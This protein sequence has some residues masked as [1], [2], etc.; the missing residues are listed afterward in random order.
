MV[1]EGHEEYN[2]VLNPAHPDFGRIR[3]GRPRLFILDPRLGPLAATT[4]SAGVLAGEFEIH[5]G[6]G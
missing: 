1:P 5:P 2:Y 6:E 4:G 3:I